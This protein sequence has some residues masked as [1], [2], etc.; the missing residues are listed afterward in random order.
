MGFEPTTSAVTGRR[1][2]Q[3]SHQAIIIYKYTLNNDFY[4]AIPSKPNTKYLL[5][6]PLHISRPS[7]RPI[8]TRQLS[9]SLCLHPRPIY[10]VL[11][12][13]PLP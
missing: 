2:N 6:L 11:Y 3:L 10:L 7:F 9:T 13:G 12:K 5:Y 4:Q 1:S 8:S